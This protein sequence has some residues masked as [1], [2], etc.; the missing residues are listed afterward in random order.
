VSALLTNYSPGGINGFL[1]LGAL[2]L[3]W[4]ERQRVGSQGHHRQATVLLLGLMV[5]PQGLHLSDSR[6]YV[7][8]MS[9]GLQCSRWV[10]ATVPVSVEALKA[11]LYVRET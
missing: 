9:V 11:G 6:E 4:A 1:G 5:L 10:P 2:R 3:L 8:D 7:H